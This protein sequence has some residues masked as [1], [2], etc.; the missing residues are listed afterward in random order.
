LFK[1]D[2]FMCTPQ[3]QQAIAENAMRKQM[4]EN[5]AE[6]TVSAGIQSVPPT[7][8]DPRQVGAAAAAG[9]AAGQ[10]GA[11][12]GVARGNP[13]FDPRMKDPRY[14]GQWGAA[15]S[16]ISE[17]FDPRTGQVT[18]QVGPP[19]EMELVPITK[20]EFDGP[21][22]SDSIQG[23]P[24]HMMRKQYAPIPLEQPIRRS[25]TVGEILGIKPGQY[26]EV[27]GP[28]NFRNLNVP[29]R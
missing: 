9:I 16:S 15:A 18:R 21:V 26:E 25:P 22:V 10:L 23:I 24:Q 13:Q 8:Y 4:E 7:G 20:E 19:K 1:A 5:I 2:K 11:G 29:L 3:I 28:G 17:M 12:P 27:G 6:G 14:A